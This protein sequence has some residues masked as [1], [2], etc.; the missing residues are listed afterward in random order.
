M[1]QALGRRHWLVAALLLA[2]LVLRAGVQLAYRPALFYIDTTRYLYPGAAQGNDPVAY[3][4]PLRGIADV[5]NLDAVAGVQHLLG[6]AM[7]VTIY[8]TLVRRGTARWLAALAV[9]PVLLDAYQLQA[10][11]TLMPDVFFEA[12]IVAGI[13]A[14]LWRP[15]TTMRTV[16]AGGLILGA[17]AP[18]RQV[19][20]IL[21]L[22]ALGYVLAAAGG[23][24]RAISQGGV[25]CVAFVVPILVYCTASLV[26]TGHFWL[27]HT[28]VTTTYGRM[29]AAADCATLRLPAGE[30]GLCPT[31]AQRALGIDGLEHSPRSPLRPYYL[32][33]TLP[34]GGASRLVSGFNRQVL[35][36]QPLRVA[37]AYGRDLTK[38]FAVTRTT[39]P[40]D[41]PI[42]RWQFQT[43]FPTYWPHASRSVI[44]TAAGAFGG[45]RPTVWRPAARFLRSYQLHGG[46]TPGPPLALATLLGLAGSLT[47]FRRRP[48]APRRQLATACLLL[49][50]SAVSVLLIS[51]LFEFSWRY[52]LPALVTLPPAGA[53]GLACLL[54]P[55]GRARHQE[56]V[57]SSSALEPAPA[58]EQRVQ[59]RHSNDLG[60][61]PEDQEGRQPA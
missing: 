31:P 41:T 15:V 30:R 12:L 13:A 39:R 23:W 53:L 3:R 57:P 16:I 43:S 18:V 36:Q 5:A 37:S 59:A 26:G 29:A 52:Q 35:G 46:Y 54:R 2:G 27:S 49:L 14:L 58:A 45:G 8:L 22:P 42:S 32:S 60:A 25:L 47:L 10:E 34:A 6:L 4:V 33:T 61:D 44:E 40:G 9:A 55:G 7:A 28:G 1:I 51:D 38:L 17:A 56:P 19:G 20:E 21:I 48:D 11:Q 24:R 50:A